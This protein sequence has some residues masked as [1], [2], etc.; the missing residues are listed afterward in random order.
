MNARQERGRVIAETCI[1]QKTGKLWYVPSQSGNGTYT[2]NL[3]RRYCSCPDFAEWGNDCKHIFAVRFTVTKTERHADGSETVTTTTVEQV[4]RTTYKQDWPNYNKAQVNSDRHFQEFLA[5]LCAPLP[6]PAPRRGQRPLPPSDAAFCAVFKTYSTMSARRF[7][8]DLEEAH[9]NGY[10]SRVPHFN[11]VLNFFDT[12]D[13]TNILHGFV[14]RSAAPLVAVETSF[15]VD[16]TGFSGAHYARWF[17][18]KYGK[19]KQKQEWMKLHAMVG[20]KT[21]VVTA[22]KV[23]DQT[24]ADAPQLPELVELTA[25][26][27][28]IEEVSADKAY[29]SRAN[30]DAV[31]KWEGQFYPQ[32]KKNATGGVG[33][34]YEKAYHLMCLNRDDYLTHYHKRSNVEASFSSLKRLFGSSLRSKTPRTMANE[35]LARV[36]CFNVT[37]VIHEMYA[38]G[39][40]PEFV[41]KPRCT[42]N[43]PPAQRLL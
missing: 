21:N 15:A 42:T 1:V 5:E 8:G 20:V 41:L 3:E 35:I 16:S 27:F 38:L 22:C 26:Q 34:A 14:A 9:G 37:C 25:K 39:I 40:N 33:G 19:P 32:F 18:E 4:Q 11:S 7:M 10:V 30:F 17:D 43:Q 2:V 6:T 24:G 13:S 28:R 12:E 23:T 36:V 31:N 29:T